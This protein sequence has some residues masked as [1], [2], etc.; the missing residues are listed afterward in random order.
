MLQKLLARFTRVGN[1]PCGQ[2]RSGGAALC[3]LDFNKQSLNV[4]FQLKTSKN[5]FFDREKKNHFLKI[6]VHG[7]L[8][9]SSRASLLASRAPV[10]SLAKQ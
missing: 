3:K 7:E 9:E 1:T 5:H 6:M 10:I 2:Q 4:P 8:G